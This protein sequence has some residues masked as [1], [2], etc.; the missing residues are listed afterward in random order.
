MIL[1]M[2]EKDIL[3]LPYGIPMPRWGRLLVSWVFGFL[4]ASASFL[5]PIPAEAF[6]DDL[7]KDLF[8]WLGESRQIAQTVLATIK[9]GASPAD[10][11]AIL[12][13]RNEKIRATS[14]QLATRYREREERAKAQGPVIMSRHQVMA[15]G[16][17]QALSEYLTLVESLP[18]GGDS[19][20]VQKLIT[21]LDR[22]LPKSRR[23]I[24]GSLPY[25]QLNLPALS[26]R[27]TPLIIPAYRGGNKTVSSDDTKSTEEAPLSKE[28][29]SLAQSLAWNPVSI[30]EYVKNTIDT[31]WYWGCRKGAEETLRQKSGNDCDQATLL[32]ALLRASGYPTRYV[33]GSIEVGMDRLKN[34]T[35]VDDPSGIADFL[36][37][38]GIPHQAVIAGGS[39]ANVKF[40]HIW[41]ESRIPYA[42]YRGVVQDE[43]GKTWL[44]LD[45]SIKVKGYQITTAKDAFQE[46]G[47]ILNMVWDEYLGFAPRQSGMETIDLNTTTPL[48]YLKARFEATDTGNTTHYTEYLSARALVPE[49]LNILPAGLQFRE[50]AITGEYTSIPSDLHQKARIAAT[51]GNT[52]LFDV[53]LDLRRL[54]G[55]M[56]TSGYEPETVLDQET[57]N[58]NGGLENTP[59]Y[60]VRLRPVLLV[61]K[62]R[63][64]VGQDGLFIGEE[65]TLTMELTA[66]GASGQR[67]TKSL[68]AGNTTAIVV[69]SRNSN[70]AGGAGASAEQAADELLFQEGINYLDRWSQAEDELAR[71]LHLSLS[72]PL[73]A[74]VTLEGVIEVASLQGIPQ[75]FTWKGV[76]IDANFRSIEAVP[77]RNQGI[78]D[79]ERVRLFMRLS[80]LQGSVLEYRIF[81]DDWQVPAISTAKLFQLANQETFPGILTVNGANSSEISPLPFDEMVKTDMVN[82][83]H[84][85]ETVKTVDSDRTYLDWTGMGYIKED[86]DT[87]AS[88]WMLTGMLAGGMTA[89]LPADWT[90][91]PLLI[92]LASAYND[93]S[94]NILITKPSNLEVIGYPR[95]SVTGYVAARNAQVFVNGIEALVEGNSFSADIELKSG[96]NKITATQALSD[97]KTVSDSITVTYKIPLKTMI[98]FPFDGADISQSPVFV[99]GMVTDPDTVVTVNGIPAT[100]TLDGKFLAQGIQLTEGQNLITATAT[101]GAEAD[102]QTITVNYA[103][104]ETPSPITVTITYPAAGKTINKPSTLVVGTVSG[105]SADEVWVKVNGMPAVVYNN[106]FVINHVP[107]T[108]GGS[109]ITADALDSKGA[110]ARA[111]VSVTANTRAPYVQLNSNIASQTAPLKAYFLVST[112]TPEAIAAY[113]MDFEGDNTT[114]QSILAFDNVTHEFTTEGIYYPTVIATDA[115]GNR[116]SDRIAVVVLGR[117]ALE[118]LLTDRWNRMK[119]ALAASDIDT[120]VKYFDEQSKGMFKDIFKSI[121]SNLQQMVNDMGEF[122]LVRVSEQFAYCDL[123]TTRNG[124]VYSF[125]VLF[126]RSRGGKWCI[127]SF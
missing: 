121:S 51:K 50:T 112:E 111:E 75:S 90:A 94:K 58:L 83:L 92:T 120:A 97:G 104:T 80:G 86:P 44:G 69:G 60:L 46:T 52:L 71:L 33:G 36:R 103:R 59:P 14:L 15:A 27:S 68:T 79:S 115:K 106:Q 37:K 22:L 84:Q 54:S 70:S 93:L 126:I 18:A 116:Y 1:M 28:I 107:L 4:F 72:R 24:I 6:D 64:A 78:A 26:P 113:D 45:T 66:P 65:Y 11:V 41:I 3:A 105:S 102:S 48:E 89:K 25:R 123:R 100:V 42:N 88:G 124:E 35:G 118:T 16:F 34:L 8:K 117:A 53:T 57:I 127:K 109:T 38:A 12:K 40:E 122:R 73:P 85:S 31:E 119:S 77:A 108:N 67:V 62:D 2:K 101:R 91:T 7:E 19:E 63:I 39:I 13:G 99:E 61:G 30:Y 49:V 110:A 96:V 17:Q 5:L 81:E 82:A 98:T 20:A 32:A 87:A 114:D 95:I 29:A 55:R 125:Q 56:V 9:S 21:L 10:R 23:S 43:Q 74:I 47:S 76:S